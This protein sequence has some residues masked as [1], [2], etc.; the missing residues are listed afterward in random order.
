MYI[1]IY[2]HT[3]IRLLAKINISCIKLLIPHTIQLFV[4]I[5]KQ[6]E[7]I[8][9]NICASVLWDIAY[10]YK[11]TDSRYTVICRYV[12]THWTEEM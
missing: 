6:K 10:L 9:I 2:T 5:D 11:Y 4:G 1:Y 3:Q 12:H 8:H 7:R